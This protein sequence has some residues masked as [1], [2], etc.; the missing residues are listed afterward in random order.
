M[1]LLAICCLLANGMPWGLSTEYRENPVGIDVRAPRLSWKLPDGFKSQAAYEIDAG[2]WASGKVGASQSVNI[3]WAGPALKTGQRVDWRVRV[4]DADGRVSAWSAPSRFVM[5]VMDPADWKAKW[6]GPNTVTRK[7]EDMCGAKWIT[8][9][10]DANGSVVLRRSFMVDELKAGEVVEMVHAQLPQHEIRIDGRDCSIYRGNICYPRF[11]RF[12]DITPWLVKGTNT[13]EVCL[14]KDETGYTDGSTYAFLAKIAFP[15][16][17]VVVTD[18]SWDGAKELGGVREIPFGRELV[19]RRETLSPAFE[20]KF[21]IMKPVKSATLH[22]TGV[23]VYEASLNGEK[24]GEKVL[25]PSPTDFDDRVLYSTYVLDG[26]LRQGENTLKVLVGHGWYDV[27]AVAVWSFENAAWRDFPRMI[28][29]LDI[30]YEDGTRETVASDR[31]WRQVGSRV[32]YDS[33]YEGEIL[34]WRARKGLPAD[35]YAE[36][37]PAPRGCLEAEKHPGAEIMQEVEPEEVKAFGNGTYVVKFP[38][39]MS[40]WVRLTLDGQRPGDLVVIRYDERANEDLSP[41]R[42]SSR[43]GLDVAKPVDVDKAAAGAE[44]RRI[45]CHFRYTASHRVT[46]VD[47]GFQTD[48]WFCSGGE[49]TYEPCFTYSGFQYVVLRGLRKPPK[50]I[51][52]CVIHT[53][54]R[55]IGT[56]RSSDATLNALV[57]MAERSYK[58]NFANGYPTDC[59]HREKN[60]WTGDASIAS[61]F[62][63]YLF[64][65]TSAYEKWLRDVCD[66]QLPNGDICCIAPTSGWGYLWGNGPAWD[67]ALPVIAWTLYNYRDDRRVLDEIYP[68]LKRYLSFTAGKSDGQGLVKHGLGDWNAVESE[69]MP[70]AELTS[71]CYYYQ[72]QVIAAR[73]AAIKGFSEDAA[74]FEVGAER[75]RRGI[76]AKFYKGDGIYDNGGQTAEALPIAFGIVESAEKD[77]VSEKLVVAVKRTDYH[78]DMGLL[79]SK[80][81]FRALSRIGRSDVALRMLLNPTKPSMVQWLQKGGT[82]LWEDWGDGASR[83][84]IMFGDFAGWVYQYLAG[85]QLPETESSCSAIPE[86]KAR[87][88]KEVVFAPDPVSELDFVSAAVDTPYGR[89]ASAWKR[90]AGKVSYSFTVPAGGS[91]TIRLPGRSDRKVGPG[92]YDL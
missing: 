85:I 33:V 73:I 68:T 7:D 24:I 28:A 5:G 43:N 77:K 54:F 37:V 83:N 55:D 50:R 27:R 45:D 48:R 38:V 70:S 62:A 40:G 79:G 89:Y 18:A 53:A 51:V 32:L 9:A 2:I 76:N 19:L 10:K 59:P 60:G 4:W 30:V 16:G 71:S 49:E 26:V 42:P 39:N 56:F 74:S 23:G 65:N 13:I 12:R 84:H 29:Q 61:E 36:E 72:A 17:H 69:H 86:V 6:I 64:E 41:A 80:H 75:T 46:P 47:A 21:T 52:A 90:D 11:A 31:T 14:V 63:Q 1:Q 58:S 8:G 25:D 57:A 91:A 66:T 67:S 22:V 34:D 82:A 15:D 92:S 35:L 20:R 78:V 44:T 81:V 88:F 3:E 87:G